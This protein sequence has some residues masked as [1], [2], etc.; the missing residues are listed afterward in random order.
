MLTMNIL[1][2][3]ADSRQEVVKEDIKLVGVKEGN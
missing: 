3:S 1:V 2:E